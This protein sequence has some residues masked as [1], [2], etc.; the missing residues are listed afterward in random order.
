MRVSKYVKVDKNILL[1]YI[2]DDGNLIS[3]SYKVGINIKNRSQSY[4][5]NDSSLTL[6]TQ[7]NTLFPIDLISNSYGIFDTETYSFLQVKDFAGGFPLRHD[8]LKIHLPVNYTFGEYLGCYVRV[9]AFDIENLNTFDLASF[10]YDKTNIEQY[11]VSANKDLLSYN[12]PPLYFQEKLW[13]KSIN[14]EIPSLFAVANQR[15]N[16]KVRTNSLNWNLTSGVGLNLNSPIFIDFS[17]ITFKSTVNSVSTYTLSNKNTITLPQT[18]EF[19][20]V[21]VKIEESVNGDFF[22]IYGVYNDNIGEFNEFINRSVSLGNRYYVEYDITIYE[23]NIRGKSIKIL[24]TDDFLSKVE[25]RPIIKYSTTTAIIDVEMRIIDAVDNSQILRKASYGMLQD[26]VS[27]YS[28]MLMKINLTNANKPKIYNQKNI[29]NVNPIGVTSSVFNQ[30]GLTVETIQVPYPV[31]IDKFNVVARSE[32]AAYSKDIYQ[33][34]GKLM[35]LVYPFDNVL[36]FVIA[37]KVEDGKISYMDLT[38]MGEIKFIIKN[39]S[40]SVEAG[41]F[42]ETGEIDLA[43]G[44]VIFKL[45]NGKINDVRKVYDTGTNVFYITSTQQNTS[46]VVYS[47]L[48][49]MYDASDNVTILNQ[50]SATDQANPPTQQEIILPDTQQTGTAIVTRK[51]ITTTPVSTPATFATFSIIEDTSTVRANE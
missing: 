30:G 14:I 31:L 41:L 6:N 29:M 21:G 18:P 11:S 22:E 3:E 9:Y 16:G 24:V 12:N 49:R 25:Y 35:I 26:Q 40:T 27:K 48:Y 39:Q 32:S 43:N 36:K 8:I 34:I 51:I 44:V 46:T 37:N 17:F 15:Q 10:Y 4:I 23:Q 13:G 28:L 33:G 38:N 42:N 50:E 7:G 1:E 20:R 45:P 2:Y 19:E 5:S 47:G